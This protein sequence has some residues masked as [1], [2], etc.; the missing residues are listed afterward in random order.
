VVENDTFSKM[1]KNNGI[2]IEA[3]RHGLGRGLHCYD[4]RYN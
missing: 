1:K 4:F 3:L 2:K